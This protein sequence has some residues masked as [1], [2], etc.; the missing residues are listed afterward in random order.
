[1]YDM[2]F[3]W[4]FEVFLKTINSEESYKYRFFLTSEINCL[5]DT[6]VDSVEKIITI[7]SLKTKDE[8]NYRFRIRTE[9]NNLELD[10][11]KVKQRGFIERLHS[12]T[13]DIDISITRQG[14]IKSI[15]NKE[16]V[17]DKW[18]V[19][20]AKLASTFKGSIVERYLNRL[21]EKIYD[22]KEF[23]KDIGQNRLLGFL[24]N[25]QYS[26]YAKTANTIVK[27]KEH[28]QAIEYYPLYVDESLTWIGDK[29]ADPIKIKISGELNERTPNSMIKK[30]FKRK[31]RLTEDNLILQD[32]SGYYIMNK[33]SGWVEDSRF[34]MGLA[35]GQNYT[36]TQQIQLQRL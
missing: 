23:L 19:L 2:K 5:N 20:K 26:I 10:F 16:E 34:T 13:E 12:L 3:L 29:E 7:N 17:I 11:L 15:N 32:Y 33:D 21:E 25:G 14:V 35:Y 4:P 22:D 6:S 31:K 30:Y 24:W 36:K 9:V 18:I 27:P 28:L 1:M 8:N